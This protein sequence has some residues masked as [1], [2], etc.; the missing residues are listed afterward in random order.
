MVTTYGLTETGSG[1]IYDGVPLDGVEV[2]VDP[3][4]GEI[5]LRGPMLLRAYRD[6]TVPLDESGWF[7]TGDVGELTTDG[8]LAVSG[9]LSEMIIS[10][11]ENI[12]PAPVEAVLRTHPGVA[13]VAVAG[14]P[15][16]EWGQ[17]VVAWVVPTDPSAPPE[18]G[19]LRDLVGRTLARY[20]APRQ[21]V[22]TSGLPKTSIGK[23][24]R[25]DLVA[26]E[27]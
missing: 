25:H 24:R 13:E 15:D 23:V 6:G 21:L 5:R 18:L 8:H 7:G 17:R 20:A 3:G 4:S 12:W 11:G 9:R 26:P 1:V 19:E 27:P 10:G 22:I 14:R 16:A 2:A